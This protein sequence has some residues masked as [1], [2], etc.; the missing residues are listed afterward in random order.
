MHYE[1]VNFESDALP[2][3]S[4]VPTDLF[5]RAAEN[6]LQNASQTSH[7]ANAKI[8]CPPGVRERSCPV[9]LGGGEPLSEGLVY[10][11]FSAPVPSMQGL[12]GPLPG[13]SRAAIALGCSSDCRVT[14]VAA[15]VSNFAPQTRGRGGRSDQDSDQ[16]RVS[17]L[18]QAFRPTPH[19]RLSSTPWRNPTTMSSNLRMQ[20]RSKPE[21]GGL[22]EP[23]AHAE[24]PCIV[25]LLSSSSTLV[26][27]PSIIVLPSSLVPQLFA[28]CEKITAGT[29]DARVRTELAAWSSPF[30]LGDSG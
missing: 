10:N 20:R 30:W 1:A 5:D 24:V 6:F 7:Y 2:E 23:V 9:R 15:Y 21:E 12:G 28:P 17:P 11:L 8:T 16:Q 26:A 13:C 25:L 29:A 14:S 22:Q 19:I 18:R 3:K 4:V 27:E